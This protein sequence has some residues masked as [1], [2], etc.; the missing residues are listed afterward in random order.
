MEKIIKKIEKKQRLQKG[1][2]ATAHVPAH[3]IDE[4]WLLI[5][6]KGLVV[7]RLATQV[8]RL[9]MGKDKAT[10]NPAV[11]AKTNVVVVNAK[12]VKL[13]GTK[14]DNKEYHYYT[15]FMGGLKTTTASRVMEGK[16]PERV[17][18]NAIHGMLPKNK[19]S[20]VMKR[21]LYLYN[22]AEHPHAGQNPIPF[23]VK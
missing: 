12:D 7:G 13:T 2:K 14:L 5:D 15:G 20:N 11:D 10:F 23:N 1:Q 6:A 8:A 17:L 19:L 4:R 3:H 21:R 22:E 16:F 18:E 9:L